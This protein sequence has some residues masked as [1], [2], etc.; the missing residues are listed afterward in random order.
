MKI[1][2]DLPLWPEAVQKAYLKSLKKEELLDFLEQACDKLNEI[3]DNLEIECE[4]A[5]LEKDTQAKILT[6]N[7][8]QKFKKQ[9]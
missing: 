3:L 9:Q 6:Q 4:N 5:Q 7:L 8:L 1:P 2:E